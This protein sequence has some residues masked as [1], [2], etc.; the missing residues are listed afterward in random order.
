MARLSLRP[1]AYRHVIFPDMFEES[2]RALNL[3][4]PRVDEIV[5]PAGSDRLSPDELDCVRWLFEQGGLEFDDYRPETI[6]RRIPACLRALRVESAARLRAAVQARPAL[7]KTAISTLVIGVTSFFRDP[8]TFAILKDSVLP[9]ML[10]RSASPRIWSAGCSD[11]SELYSVAMLLAERG[12]L[13]RS[14]LLGT[15]CRGDALA[16]A[17]E[18]CYDQTAVRNIPPELLSRYMTVSHDVW[19]IHPYLR[20]V[21]QWRTGNVMTI[22]EPGIWNLI[23]CRNLAIYLQP[24]AMQRLWRRLEESL[25]PGGVLVLGKAERPHGTTSLEPIAPGIY[26]RDRS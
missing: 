7:L 23:L 24:A 15:D 4:P 1:I 17:R 21:V 2:G 20:T 14:T 19:Q 6:K 25:R 3:T 11:G 8:Q 16:R 26:R 22:S 5:P 12:A 9:E 13:Q 18:G 10:M